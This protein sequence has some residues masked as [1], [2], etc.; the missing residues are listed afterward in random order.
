MIVTVGRRT[1]KRWG[2]LI[3][4]LTTRAVHLEIAGSLTPSFAILTL[5]R[6]MARHGTPTVMYSDNATDF[7]KADKE[8]REATSEVEK[9]ATVK[10]IMWKFIPP[11]APHLGGA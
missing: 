8:L 1:Q 6:F 7:T 4:C 10:R 9:Y 2:L 5:R 3:T 11:G